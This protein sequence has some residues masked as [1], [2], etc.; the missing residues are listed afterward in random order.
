[1][2][3]FDNWKMKRSDWSSL[4][5]PWI[6]IVAV[7]S[8]WAV[9][10]DV[11]SGD[12]ANSSVIH[13][14]ILEVSSR[15]PPIYN[16]EHAPLFPLTKS[17]VYG[18]TLAIL[19]LMVAAGGGIGG[20]GILVPIYI[21]I[22]GFSPKHAIPLSNITVFGGAIANTYLNT[23]KRHPLADRPLVDWDLI[24]VMEP[25]TI[26]GALLGAF[27][28]KVLPELLLTVLLVVLLSFTANNTL[29]KATNMYKKETQALRSASKA[30][31]SQL[32]R[33]AA[34]EASGEGEAAQK[35]LDDTD[36][37]E[38]E[39]EEKQADGEKKEPIFVNEEL[40]AI[41][42]EEKVVPE[43]NLKILVTLFVVVLAINLLKG[44]GAFKSPIG[45]SCGSTA[46][47]IANVAML[48]WILAI[49]VYVRNILLQKNDAKERCNYK[50]VE[51]DIKWDAKATVQYPV[52][53]CLAG[54]FA[55]MFGVGK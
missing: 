50:F 25:L 38:S 28:N 5:L 9:T 11:L 31:E 13:R 54:F 27:L 43:T 15:A 47:W 46:F 37:K 17:D 8:F 30:G 26:A 23:K 14:S 19:G 48:V 35:L 51:G 12:D 53:C 36:E 42:E 52:V 29:R 55:G 44:G 22:F 20:G 32:T 2:V 3:T 7:A 6:G 49:S 40:E 18:F 1:M 39:D 4:V 16:E 33:M 21:L 34:E 10:S 41:L 45:I 24:L